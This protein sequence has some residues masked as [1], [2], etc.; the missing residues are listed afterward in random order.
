MIPI[1]TLHMIKLFRICLQGTQHSQWQAKLSQSPLFDGFQIN[2]TSLS[3]EPAHWGFSA[4]SD[5]QHCDSHR[6][7]PWP[8]S[9]NVG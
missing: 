3:L 2:M 9:A 5:K 4:V 7:D 8:E 1:K 6:Q